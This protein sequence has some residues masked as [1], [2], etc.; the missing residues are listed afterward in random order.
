MG[1]KCWAN[2]EP[3]TEKGKCQNGVFCWNPEEL[4]V[5]E[6]KERDKKEWG[7]KVENPVKQ[8]HENSSDGLEMYLK[9]RG[10]WEGDQEKLVQ[11]SM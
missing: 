10:I 9:A 8:M 3:G 11:N 6:Q 1:Q 4:I 7:L 2:A 5:Q